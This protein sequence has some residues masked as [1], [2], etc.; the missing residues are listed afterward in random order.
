MTHIILLIT[1]LSFLFVNANLCV[2]PHPMHALMSFL[3]LFL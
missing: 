3:P 1:F 2:A